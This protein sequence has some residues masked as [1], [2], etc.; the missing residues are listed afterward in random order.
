M[1]W[2]HTVR[3][4]LFF[5]DSLDLSLPN[6]EIRITEHTEL[7]D[8]ATIKNPDNMVEMPRKQRKMGKEV[9]FMG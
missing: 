9:A 8:N 1:A 6:A 3:S 5:F 4:Q 7:G 2:K